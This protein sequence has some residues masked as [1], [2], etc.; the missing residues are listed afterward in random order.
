M[1]IHRHF[2]VE[3]IYKYI[4]YE[5]L[6]IYTFLCKFHEKYVLKKLTVTHKKPR[7]TFQG[8]WPDEKSQLVFWEQDS[9]CES[10]RSINFYQS[11][12]VLWEVHYWDKQYRMLASEIV[13]FTTCTYEDRKIKRTF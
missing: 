9:V 3:R 5:Y 10:T 1:P 6:K 2:K 13:R 11:R 12:G 7:M 8:N 4:L